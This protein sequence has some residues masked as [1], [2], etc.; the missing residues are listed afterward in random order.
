MFGIKSR[1]DSAPMAKASSPCDS[2]IMKIIQADVGAVIESMEV[3]A[4]LNKLLTGVDPCFDKSKHVK[5][6]FNVGG[7]DIYILYDIKNGEKVFAGYVE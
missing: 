4:N 2:G 3:I 7:D 5:V 1:S 6:V